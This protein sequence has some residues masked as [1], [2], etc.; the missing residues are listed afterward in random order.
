MPGDHGSEKFQVEDSAFGFVVMEDGATI[1]L[2]SSWALN[3]LFVGEARTILHGTE[4]GADMEDGP[5]QR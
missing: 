5:Y 4:G 2:E 1:I 3:T